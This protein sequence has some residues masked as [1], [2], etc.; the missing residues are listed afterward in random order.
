M[1]TDEAICGPCMYGCRCAPSPHIPNGLDCSQYSLRANA[2]GCTGRLT[3]E[4]RDAML[5]R[6]GVPPLPRP[7]AV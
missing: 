2:H 7:E 5:A 1:A 3:A 6:C 4:Q